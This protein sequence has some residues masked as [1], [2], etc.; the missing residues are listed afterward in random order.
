MDEE[1]KVTSLVEVTQLPVIENQLARVLPE[2]KQRCEIAASLVVNEDN[3]KDMKKTRAQLNREYSEFKGL[4]K[5]IKEVVMAPLNDFLN[6][7][8]KEV[9]QA[10]SNGIAQ[11]DGNIKETENGLK[12]QKRV[13]LMEYYDEYRQSL[14]LDK[15]IADP[16]RSGIKVGLTGSLK[17]YKEQAKAYLDRIANDLKTIA[18]MENC[19]EIMAEYTISLDMNGAI[20][21]VKDRIAREEA[22]RKARVEAEA[23]RLAQEAHEAEVSAAMA[24]ATEAT[25]TPSEASG[26]SGDILSPPSAE[27]LS[28]DTTEPQ[29][30]ESDEPVYQTAFRVTGTLDMLREL[31]RFLVGGGY[32]FETIKEGA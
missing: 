32:V 25:E 4:I 18:L 13:A 17:S 21:I 3:Y 12:D 28:G 24:D 8:C 6:G 31:K 27:K 10:Y 29:E 2:I 23:A 14:Q 30:A 11:L 1:V 16:R 20:Q 26:D 22:A 19:D 15:Q 7:I 9:D 5:N